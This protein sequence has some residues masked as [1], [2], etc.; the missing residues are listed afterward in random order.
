MKNKVLASVSLGFAL[1]AAALTAA[2]V[3]QTTAVHTKPDASSPAFTYLK[4]GTEPVPASGTLADTPAGWMAIELPGPVQGY[5]DKNKD[6]TKALDV[7]PGTSIRATP[8]ATGAV[9]AVAEAGDK[10][11]ITGIQGRWAQVS[12]D[13]KLTGYIRVG[14]APGYL[15]PIATTPAGSAPVEPAPA[16]FPPAT[17]APSVAAGQAVVSSGTGGN[18]SS[19]LPRQFAGKFMSTRAPLRPRRPYDWELVDNAGKRITYIDISKLLLTEQIEK[20][21]NH[22]VVVFGAVKPTVDG[23]DIVM[24]VESLQLR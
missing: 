6:M 16:P 15:P 21:N 20:Y 19:L 8:S 17:V 2:P 1:L 10:S 18:S 13:K 22:N 24:Q 12:L 9:V 4:A 11:T 14:N 23:K 5:V 3:T 7:K